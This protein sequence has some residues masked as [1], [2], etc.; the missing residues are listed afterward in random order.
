MGAWLNVQLPTKPLIAFFAAFTACAA[1][2][3]L[4][5]WKPK[6]GEMSPRG[7]MIL[8]L[9]AGSVLGLVAGLIGRGGGS[10]V[11]PLLYIAGLEAKAAAAT[12]SFVV[13]CSG[14]SS[15]FAHLATAAQPNR[16]LWVTCGLAVFLGSQIGS[17][18]MA[19][20]LRPRGV[21]TIFGIVL[22]G[23]AILLLVKD[24]ILK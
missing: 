15:F 14:I 3:M 13:S 21:R 1:T 7:R 24:V 9:S 19:D 8:G 20:G 11:V 23:V 2:L 22:W 4:S 17:R 12:S 16:A 18:I 10:F 5:G 6:R